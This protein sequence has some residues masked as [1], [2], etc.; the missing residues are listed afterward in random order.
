[1]RLQLRYLLLSWAVSWTCAIALAP[2][3]EAQS[4]FQK[5]FGVGPGQAP[6]PAARVPARPLPSVRFQHRRQRSWHPSIAPAEEE[7]GPPDSGGPYRTVCVRACDGFYFPLRQNAWRR[8]FASDVKSCR[9][10]CGEEARLYYYPVNSG[11]TDTMT[12]LAGRPYTEMPYAFAY[13]KALV[14]GCSCKPAPWSREEAARHQS[15]A[16]AE[17]AEVQASPPQTSPQTT[18][19]LQPAMAAPEGEVATDPSTS[20]ASAVPSAPL[21][22]RIMRPGRPAVR[23]ARRKQKMLHARMRMPQQRVYAAPKKASFWSLD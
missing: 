14:S 16:V 2:P 8:N 23:H 12:D 18:A 5:L 1:M 15:Y 22:Y 9:N 4:F 3:A 10:A 7:I 13:R 19:H 17:A 6:P 11:S 21:S 20:V